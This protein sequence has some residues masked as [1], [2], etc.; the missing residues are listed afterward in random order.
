MP[1]TLTLGQMRQFVLDHI[2]TFVRRRELSPKQASLVC[3]QIDF[4]IRHHCTF[5]EAL[6]KVAESTPTLLGKRVSVGALRDAWVK[7]GDPQP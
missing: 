1:T 7:R 3:H 2:P 6:R 5:G 4:F